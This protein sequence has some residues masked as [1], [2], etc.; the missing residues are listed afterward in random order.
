MNEILDRIIW[1]N[2]ILSY[3]LV[4]LGILVSWVVVKLVKKVIVSFLKKITSRTNTKFDDLLVEVA[5]RFLIPFVYLVIN[6]NIIRQ[7]NLSIYADRVLHVAAMLVTTY[8]A[9]RLINFTIQH[10]VVAYM[11]S[12]DEPDERINQVQGMLL[13]VKVVTWVTGFVMLADNLGYNVTTII[14]GFGVGGIAIALAAQSILG[15]LFSYIVIFFD[16]PFE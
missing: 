11:K 14:A 5:E 12:K 13:V 4:A 9:V 10:L 3:L 2:T 7:L 8:Y 6:Y 1:G 15:D 16:K